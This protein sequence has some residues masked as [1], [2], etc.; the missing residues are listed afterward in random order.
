[1]FYK[2]IFI[3]YHIIFKKIFPIFSQI[4]KSAWNDG[5]GDVDGD[6]ENFFIG[7]CCENEMP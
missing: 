7:K 3:K 2:K 4:S 6:G 5:D 1:M